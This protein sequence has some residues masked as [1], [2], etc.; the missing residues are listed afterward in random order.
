MLKCVTLDAVKVGQTV[1][2]RGSRAYN[3]PKST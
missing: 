3:P 1:T 2:H